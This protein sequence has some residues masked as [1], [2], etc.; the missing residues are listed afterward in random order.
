V[1]RVDLI[2]PPAPSAQVLTAGDVKPFARVT[3]SAEDALFPGFVAAA[4]TAAEGWMQRQLLEAT[5]ERVL[6]CFPAC[7][8][9]I[10]LLP[11]PLVQ[12]ASVKYRDVDGIEQTLVVDVDYAVIKPLGPKAEAGLVVPLV[13]W[14]AT[15]VDVPDVVRV[16]FTAGYGALA[17]AIPPAILEA[18]K[19]GAAEVW[20][21]REQADPL[22]AMLC[23][24]EDF[25][26]EADEF[27]P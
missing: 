24:L 19:K 23:D 22:A 18:L 7:R 10:R 13:D 8:G 3:H 17:N 4:V 1:D 2:T 12:V 16:R 5:F 20:A 21:R 15:Q 26:V 14:P 9:A 27:R 6:D 11:A 25:R